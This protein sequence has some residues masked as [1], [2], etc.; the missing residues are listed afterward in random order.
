[1]GMAAGGTQ[2]GA[3]G[4]HAVAYG[5]TGVTDQMAFVRT[6]APECRRG[7][8][9]GGTGERHGGTGILY[10]GID[11][12]VIQVFDFVES[13]AN[14]EEKPYHGIVGPAHG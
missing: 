7:G 11:S 8:M 13:L 4:N 5:A 10:K 3:D 2:E 12:M 1:M 6:I 9:A 14:M